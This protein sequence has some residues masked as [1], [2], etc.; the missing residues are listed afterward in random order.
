VKSFNNNVETYWF[1][2][3][4]LRMFN[5]KSIKF[6][7]LFILITSKIFS[8]AIAKTYF[9]QEVNYKINVSLN[10]KNNLLN[11]F[12]EIVYT[13]NSPDT[14]NEL[15]FHLYPN[16]Y[17]NDSTALNKQMMED[18]E[19]QLF[20]AKE[21]SRGY[22]DS[23]NFKSNNE[24]LKCIFHPQFIDVCKLALNNPLL[25]GASIIITTPF[26][27]KI[28]TAS[29]SKLG[30]TGQ[31]YAISQWY[32]KPAVYDKFGWHAMPYLNQG[33]FFSEYGS[34]EVNITLPK[35]YV[36]GATGDLQ[37]EDEIRWM[38]VKANETSFIKD[39]TNDM[40]FPPSDKETKTLTYKQNNIHDFAWFADKRFHI[41]K[42]ETILPTSD[43]KITTWALF[44]NN[45]PKLW[46]KSIEFINDALTYYSNW[47][48]D[49]PYKQFTCVDGT[50][51]AG[52]GMEYPNLTIIG[53]SNN[54]VQ[55][56]ITIIHEIGHSWFY[57]ILGSNEREHPWMDEGINSYYEMRYALKKYPPTQYRGWN[58][59][60]G[61]GKFGDIIGTSRI[62]YR[63]A[64]DLEYKY[65]AS[66]HTDQAIEGRSE[67]FTQANY[68]LIVYKKTGNAFGYLKE[69]LG[70]TLFDNCM[71]NYFEQ[72]KYK[73][74]YPEDLELVFKNN[75]K[76]DLS[77][78]FNDVIKTNKKT[79]YAITKISE[80]AE[81]FKVNIR[82]KGDFLPP[83]IISGISNKKVVH[84]QWVLPSATNTNVI[85]PYTDC[86]A[87]ALDPFFETLDFQR[88]NNKIRTHG[89]FKKLERITISVPGHLEYPYKSYLFALP[90]VAY[91]EYNKFMLGAVLHNTFLPFKKL[92]YI[93]SPLYSFSQHKIVGAGEINYHIYPNSNSIFSIVPTIRYRKFAFE[94]SDYL[95]IDQK[96]TNVNLEY[97]RIEPLLTF[98]IRPKNPR[99][100]IRQIVQVSAVLLNAET[101]NYQKKDSLN[102]AIVNNEKTAFYRAKY[103]ISNSKKIDPW[104]IDL[105]YEGNSNF[106][107]LFTCINYKINYNS[108]NKGVN[109]RI[110][111]GYMF[112]DKV[113]GKYGFSLSENAGLRDYA[114]DEWY[115]GRTSIEGVLSHQIATREGNFKVYNALGANKKWITSF[116]INADLPISLPL[117][118]FADIGTT[119]GYKNDIP[120]V[121]DAKTTFTYDFG[122]CIKVFPNAFEVYIPIA[123]SKEIKAINDFNKIKFGDQIRFM[124]NI[125]NLNPMKF[126][127]K[128]IGY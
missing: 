25:P 106:G 68:G 80:V 15:W 47:I 9:Q 103:S 86:E 87:I 99:S 63:E 6:C 69:F 3:L 30:H 57:G 35:N 76:Q 55:L 111:A 102:F 27:V 125:A 11:A 48:G 8:Q 21:E 108:S 67:D 94:N 61:I 85:I 77:W 104:N 7:L 89:I 46:L 74:P 83:I 33:E 37:N 73:H 38:N 82:N 53:T 119:E 127:T 79:D 16:A 52:S 81:G 20:F 70:N 72:W 44:T 75:C 105:N 19:T 60:Y 117:Q 101:I 124:F 66:S 65:A 128:F 34:F 17:K 84:K 126:R 114:F 31:A 109:F 123:V 42:G 93:I 95:N 110:F 24:L 22:I 13:N 100:N 112:N 118:L 64:A 26:R 92:E 41:L 45:E 58:E 4:L 51:A 122:V 96:L 49:Y 113:E 2:F 14:L 36:V 23:L 59:L 43:N 56:E 116:N 90:T 39:F 32:P 98:N 88:D 54:T 12:E 18:G 50:I 10:D 71:K 91:N 120:T 121:Y 107:K 115:F 1:D 28:P 97:Q 29:I 62:N 78:F 40:T 5:K